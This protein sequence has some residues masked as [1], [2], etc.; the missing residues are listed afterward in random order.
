MWK[1]GR[2][3]EY[4]MDRSYVQAGSAVEDWGGVSQRAKTRA[5]VEMGYLWGLRP[6]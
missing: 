5:D 4:G 2:A 3:R 1:L 6:L